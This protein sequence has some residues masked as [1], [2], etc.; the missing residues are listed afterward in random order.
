MMICLVI[1]IMQTS[2][3]K[4]RWRTRAAEGGQHVLPLQRDRLSSL[5]SCSVSISLYSVVL[6]TS[7][8]ELGRQLCWKNASFSS[9]KT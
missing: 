2:A 7:I 4:S 3:L 1:D 5:P 9:M 6:Y 8:E